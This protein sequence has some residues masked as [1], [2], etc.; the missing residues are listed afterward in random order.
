MGA[1]NDANN[2][3]ARCFG[4]VRHLF[5]CSLDL[6]TKHVDSRLSTENKCKISTSIKTMVHEAEL[7]DHSIR[8]TPSMMVMLAYKTAQL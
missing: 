1:E 7:G 4:Y 5:D 2:D 6:L 8:G 3:N